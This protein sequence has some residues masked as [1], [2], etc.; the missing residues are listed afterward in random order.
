MMACRGVIRETISMAFFSKR[1]LSPVERF[2]NALKE[3][4]TARE[5]L[6]ERLKAAEGIPTPPA[7]PRRFV[8]VERCE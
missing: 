2:E 3:K 7:T 5:N 8:M 1:A 4:Q 6:A